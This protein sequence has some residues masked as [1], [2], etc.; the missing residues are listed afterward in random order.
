[1]TEHI[2]PQALRHFA[3][4]FS[5]VPSHPCNR[6]ADHI[7]ALQEEIQKLKA[8]L[9]SSQREENATGSQIT[10][11]CCEARANRNALRILRSFSQYL[12]DGRP[13]PGVEVYGG[14]IEIHFSE[15]L[16]SYLEWLANMP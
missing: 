14:E 16:P 3:D 4:F 12:S 6:A 8:D 13:P 10:E 15:M 7:E 11:L 1:M 5:P 2:T 9:A